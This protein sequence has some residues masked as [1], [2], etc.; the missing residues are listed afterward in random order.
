MGEESKIEIK[1]T[2]SRQQL[3]D[4]L[5][6]MAEQVVRGEVIIGGRSILLPESCKVEIEY[7]RSEEENEI[8]IE[9]KW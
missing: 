2:M 1:E 9:I 6:D 8:E 3:A 7:E 5:R 4:L